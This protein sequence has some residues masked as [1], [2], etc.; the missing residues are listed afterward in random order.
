MRGCLSVMV[1]CIGQPLKRLAGAYAGSLNPIQPTAKSLRPF[2][3]GLSQIDIGFTTMNT[4]L[5][6]NTARIP[7]RTPL[8]S[9]FYCRQAIALGIDGKL[10]MRVKRRYPAIVV[11]FA[12][13]THTGT[14]EEGV[15]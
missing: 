11:K 14:S 9:A 2:G 5:Q 6:A 1:G 12:G 3:G 4:H 15:L 13:F 10:A 7:T 8:F